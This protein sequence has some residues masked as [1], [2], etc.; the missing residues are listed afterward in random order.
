MPSSSQ[1]TAGWTTNV[2]FVVGQQYSNKAA[3]DRF[4]VL[5]HRHMKD[6]E[7]VTS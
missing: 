4:Q 3:N 6:Y 1:C 7:E 2:D 5:D